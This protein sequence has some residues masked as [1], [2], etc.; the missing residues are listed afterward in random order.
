MKINLLKSSVPLRRA[1][2]GRPVTM[3]DRILE[4]RVLAVHG[5][6]RDPYG[7]WVYEL[8]PEDH[9]RRFGV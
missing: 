7:V 6:L 9:K 4:C 8:D 3:E 5:P 2:D 1:S